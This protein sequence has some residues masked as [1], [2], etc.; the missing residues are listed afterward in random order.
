MTGSYTV[1]FFVGLFLF[2]FLFQ[3]CPSVS[4]PSLLHSSSLVPFFLQISVTLV[5]VIFQKARHSKHFNALYIVL[6]QIIKQCVLTLKT[7]ASNN[8]YNRDIMVRL[9]MIET[10]RRLVTCT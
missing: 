1:E 5:E 10:L 7:L 2:F 6:N 8:Q 3:P 9:G 4:P